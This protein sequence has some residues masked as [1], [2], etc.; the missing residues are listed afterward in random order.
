MDKIKLSLG[1]GLLLLIVLTIP[2]IV[3]FN[4]GNSNLRKQIG[5][6]QKQLGGLQEEITVLKTANITTALGIVEVPPN[7]VNNFWGSNFSHVWITGWVFNSGASPAFDAELRVIAINETGVIM[8][9]TIP[10]VAYGT[11]STDEDKIKPNNENITPYTTENILS[12]QNKTISISIYH[13]G[14]FS[15]NTAY[16]IIPIWKN[17]T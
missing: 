8:N 3:Y 1:F 13:E 12:Y 7:Y 17:I 2:T 5:E 4:D 6:L 14:S 10:L 9:T 11:F 16:E 15:S